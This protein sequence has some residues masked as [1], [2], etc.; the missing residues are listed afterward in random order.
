[1]SKN[2]LAHALVGLAAFSAAVLLPTNSASASTSPSTP[3]LGMAQLAASAIDH[4]DATHPHCVAES[5]PIGDTTLQQSPHCFTTFGEAIAYATNGRI[6][7]ANAKTAR[8]VTEAELTQNPDPSGSALAGTTTVVSIH[9]SQTGYTGSTYSLT[10]VQNPAGTCGYTQL[11]NFTSGW[12]DNIMSTHTY[13]NCAT[14]LF[15]DTSFGLPTYP[16]HVNAS[17]S[18]LGSFNNE[19]S[20]EKWCPAYACS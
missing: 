7:L 9:Y 6:H 12:N 14:T 13:G 5:K 4:K 20:S 11:S 17:V 1:M 10:Q 3:P 18:T 16:I 19:A 2:R 15:Y 8:E